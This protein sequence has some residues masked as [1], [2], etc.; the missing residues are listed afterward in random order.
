MMPNEQVPALIEE[1]CAEVIEI[2]RS[3]NHRTKIELEGAY[4]WGCC[5][6][7]GGLKKAGIL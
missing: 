1:E 2:T 7:V 3:W 4:F 6:S 5:D